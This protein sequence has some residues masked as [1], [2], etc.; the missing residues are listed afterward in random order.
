MQCTTEPHFQPPE[1]GIFKGQKW[2]F[3]PLIFTMCLSKPVPAEW[4]KELKHKLKA[5]EMYSIKS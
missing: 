1:M 5:Q 4:K 3:Y 2:L